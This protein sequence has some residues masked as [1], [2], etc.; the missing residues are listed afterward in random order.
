MYT[1]NN[2]FHGKHNKETN[3]LKAHNNIISNLQTSTS[4][5]PKK[6]NS[7]IHFQSYIFAIKLRINKVQLDV[8]PCRG[9][10]KVITSCLSPFMLFVPNAESG[11]WGKMSEQR[12][13][14]L[15]F[16]EKT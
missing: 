9:D 5:Y 3:G 8:L 4:S 15:R 6:P 1:F 7:L 16:K 11:E 12:I 10:A 2:I 14:I 13:I